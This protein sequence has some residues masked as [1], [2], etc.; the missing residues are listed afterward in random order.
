MTTF[1]INDFPPISSL[2]A[3][4][5]LLIWDASAGTTNKV[6]V[7]AIAALVSTVAVSITPSVV[8]DAGAVMYTQFSGNTG[9]AKVTSSTEVSAVTA[10]PSS[11]ITGLGDL[12]TQ[13]NVSVGQV[14]G[15]ASVA[16]TGSYNDLSDTPTI[17]S[18]LD[19][20]SD[21]NTSGASNGNV[22]TFVSGVWVPTSV[23]G[24]SG[25][26]VDAS[27]ISAAGGILDSQFTGLGYVKKTGTQTFAG[28]STI[29]SSDITGLGTLAAQNTI[30]ISQIS[31][32]GSIGSALVGSSTAASVQSLLNYSTVSA[33]SQ[34][35]DTSVVNATSGEYLKYDGTKWVPSSVAGGGGGSLSTL[36]DVSLGTPTDLQVLTYDAS[37]SKWI[38]SD[39]GSV[40][41]SFV[42]FKTRS[43]SSQNVSTGQSIITF[44]EIDYDTNT[45]Y[46]STS[47]K[48]TPTV[49]GVYNFYA[50]IN[51]STSA[52]GA[53][54][55]YF[56]K[57]DV[58]I[59]EPIQPALA[60]TAGGTRILTLNNAVSMN[61]TTDYV[62]LA[63]NV[64]A[65][66]AA[67]FGNRYLGG[68]LLTAGTTQVS[69]ATVDS[70][71]VQAAGAMMTSFFVD[72]SGYMRKTSASSYDVTL[73]IPVAD[74]TGLNTYSVSSGQV[75][76]LSPIA[77]T[78]TVASAQSYL[79]MNALAVTSTPSSALDLLGFTPLTKTLVSAATSDIYKG[80]L[81]F[82][83]LGGQITSAGTATSVNTLLGLG[84][85]ATTNTAASA[86]SFIEMTSIGTDL[87]VNSSTAASVRSA[88]ELGG[89]ATVATATSGRT[90][91]GFTAYGA[92]LVSAA[93]STAARGVL[94]YPNS[95]TTD[96][97]L[98]RFDG[99]AGL[100]QNSP[101]VV[102][103][104][105]SIYGYQGKLNV[106]TTAYTLVSSDTGKIIVVNNSTSTIITLPNSM[107][108]GFNSTFIQSGSGVI[109]FQA[110]T[111][112][113]IL[114][115]QSY[116]KSAG[117]YAAVG[118]F[119][120]ENSNGT[121]GKYIL[122][123][124]M[125]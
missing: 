71:S 21:V 118:L 49:A 34:L 83:T 8:A 82:S 24:G 36:S 62:Q 55:I 37:S 86:R 78:S 19:E 94:G 88:L 63:G 33:L 1:T 10:I 102:E 68:Y 16:I 122:S 119:V 17:P 105:A 108:A 73:G 123:G 95:G 30:T 44:N 65:T 58:T 115:R 90:F 100:I 89:L 2:S 6:P 4:D 27:S 91:L 66:S 112:A 14:S 109:Q 59:G 99:T 76:G 57:N 104:A 52:N 51:M 20:L 92:T 47:S 13:N 116:T 98:V 48:Y 84:T 103:D 9:Y 12:A 31:D 3:Q 75:S 107:Q 81:G 43:V 5:E 39:A 120:S 110:A 46:T 124:D 53:L 72:A 45:A 11:D 64:I 28:V 77:Y 106:V 96:N 50:G 56:L 114:Q 67:S 40:S 97:A 32:A 93:D 80:V 70:S 125:A 85:L 22:L 87:V 7:S 35:S 79:N 69:G 25:G 113:S 18:T 54:T 111:S 23:T 61:G 74:I 117:Q 121:A 15:L 101:I 29:P 42:G 60:N 38:A 41:A 26:T